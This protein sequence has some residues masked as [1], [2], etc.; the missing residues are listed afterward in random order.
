M[1]VVRLPWEKHLFS[2][3]GKIEGCPECTKIPEELTYDISNCREFLMRQLGDGWMTVAAM[4]KIVKSSSDQCRKM[5]ATYWM[6]EQFLLQEYDQLIDQH[7]KR[8]FLNCLPE[9]GQKRNVGRAQ[10]ACRTLCTGQIVMAQAKPL[11]R[12]LVGACNILSDMV[13]GRGPSPQ[14]AA[15]YGTF[16]TLVLKRC[17]NFAWATVDENVAGSDEPTTKK[18]VCGQMAVKAKFTEAQRCPGVISSADLKFLRT[19]KWCLSESEVETFENWSLDAVKSAKERVTE[20]RA[21]ALKDIEDGEE[22]KRKLMNEVA[23]SIVMAPPIAPK[24][25]RKA[26]EQE[27]MAA[28]K[29]MPEEEPVQD[30]DEISSGGNSGVMSFFGARAL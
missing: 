10:L 2:E 19:F 7:L 15:K 13:D 3:E 14:D 17:E 16:V 26:K 4:K 24:K 22:K 8:C 11:E 29:N 21:K 20:S 18:E 12:E 6:D 5:D 30:D 23:S 1:A 25:R 9:H 27:K 28:V